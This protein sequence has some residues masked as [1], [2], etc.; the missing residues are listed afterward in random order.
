MPLISR[1]DIRCH[2]TFIHLNSIQ[3]SVLG[4]QAPYVLPLLIFRRQHCDWKSEPACVVSRNGCCVTSCLVNKW[5]PELL[6]KGVK[7]LVVPRFNTRES[8]PN[9][10]VRASKRVP[11]LLHHQC[12]YVR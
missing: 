3:Y 1:N 8:L 5:S 11:S 2:E 7:L 4:P 12:C 10:V 9:L 6:Y